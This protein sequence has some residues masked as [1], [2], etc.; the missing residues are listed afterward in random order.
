MSRPILSPMLLL[1]LED[2][3]ASYTVA[4]IKTLFEAA[5]IRLPEGYVLADSSVRRSLVKGYI[6]TLDLNTWVQTKKLITVIES[7]MLEMHALIDSVDDPS[8]WKSWH[9][10]TSAILEKITA[11]LTTDGFSYREGRL[12]YDRSI[13]PLIDAPELAFEELP[14]GTD[15]FRFQFPA[16]LPF[17]ISK[18]DFAIV[19]EKGFQNLRFELKQDMFLL[20]KDVYPNLNYR[21][22][23]ELC[24]VDNQSDTAFRRQLDQMC[25]S[26]ERDFFRAYGQTFNMADADIPVL[27]PQAWVQW[28]SLLK[29]DLR[30]QNSSHADE[31]YRIDF[32]AFWSDR[33][34]A[35]MIDD[36]SHYAKKPQNVWHADEE[37]YSKRLKEDRKLQK[38]QWK[39]FRLSNWEIKN[40]DLLPEI[41]NDLKE[42]IGFDE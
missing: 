24:G 6:S 8:E 27:I 35:I 3:L 33:R 25:T 17:G 12:F 26:K 13:N 1:A 37:S 40:K 39:V 31:L 15:P 11:Y 42:F 14:T 23:M 9:E 21:K 2:R 10:D 16:G 30:A 19:A 20:R 28:H 18:P 22:L 32:V 7:V 36:I 29:R 34:Y 5:G 4:Q 38:E 41:L